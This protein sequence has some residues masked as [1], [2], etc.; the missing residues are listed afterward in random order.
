MNEFRESEEPEEWGRRGVREWGKGYFS[1]LLP[2]T[3]TPPLSRLSGL[4]AGVRRKIFCN[5]IGFARKV[6]AC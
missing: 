6:L 2:N 3:L 1:P 5:K 4:S